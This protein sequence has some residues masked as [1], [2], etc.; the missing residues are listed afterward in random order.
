M[1]VKELIKKLKEF[2]E[3]T[4]VIVPES[5]EAFLVIAKDVWLYNN[6]QF[7]EYVGKVLITGE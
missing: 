2:D 5:Y 7:P 6:R 3:N 4:E 1:T